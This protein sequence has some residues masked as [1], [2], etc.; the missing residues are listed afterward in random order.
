MG[1]T[2]ARPEPHDDGWLGRLSW[3]RAGV[4]GANDGIVSVAAVLV[5]VAGVT[6][7]SGPLIT[8]G[9][10]ALVGG[11]ISMALGEYVS[12]SSQRDGERALIEL[13]RRE[14]AEDPEGELAELVGLWEER[15]LDHETATLVAT[16]MT[17]HDALGAHLSLELG[18]DEETTT[19]PWT[20]AAASL[21]AFTIGG[22]LPFAAILLAPTDVRVVV[23]VVV[24]LVALGITGALGARLGRA[25]WRIATLRVIVGGGVALAVT[26][27]IGSLLGVAGVG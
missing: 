27:A 24:V 5:G 6:T 17:E 9:V 4:L 23:A 2:H 25:P 11:A 1:D 22:A 20:A 15:G 13:E 16:R 14:L 19:S 12:V 26:Y 10:A 8:A 21:L 7:A 3:L 18:I